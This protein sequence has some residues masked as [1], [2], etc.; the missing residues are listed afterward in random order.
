MGF[1]IIHAKAALILVLFPLLGFQMEKHLTNRQAGYTAAIAAVLLIPVFTPYQYTI[2]YV[3][4]ILILVLAAA[5]FSF[6]LRDAETNR[7]KKRM[8]IL[9]SVLLLI[10]LG[11][12]YMLSS[13]AGYTEVDKTWK[14]NGYRVEYIID[15]GFAGG[16]GIYYKLSKYTTIPLFV[17]KLEVNVI[18]SDSTFA[19]CKMDFL[20]SRVQFD[21]CAGTITKR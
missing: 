18:E 12:F 9:N 5:I 16:P 1:I 19:D 8:T 10:P 21:K 15:Q 20:E 11:F 3:F 17:R 6:M 4:R 14:S 13:F 2:P 7:S